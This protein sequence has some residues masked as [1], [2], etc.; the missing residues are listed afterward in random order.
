MPIGYRVSGVWNIKSMPY[1]KV[2]GIWHLCKE[3]VY[4]QS[5]WH[6]IFTDGTTWS[7]VAN[8]GSYM[9]SMTGDPTHGI[10]TGGAL[11]DQQS[12]NSCHTWNGSS[13]N[14]IQDLPSNKTQHGC[15][16][17]SVSC[18]VT[19]GNTSWNTSEIGALDEGQTYKWSG[20]SWSLTNSSNI[21]NT[22]FACIGDADNGMVVG[23]DTIV[24]NMWN[25]STWSVTTSISTQGSTIGCGD[26]LNALVQVQV[27]TSHPTATYVYVWNGSTWSVTTSTSTV[28][29]P[30]LFGGNRWAAL[31]STPRNTSRWTGTTWST[32]NNASLIDTGYLSVLAY[33]SN[34]GN[35]VH[36]LICGECVYNYGSNDAIKWT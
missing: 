29:V 11:T 34:F 6:T 9:G 15:F 19:G 4:K 22:S 33:H 8:L 17:N 12:I 28:Y 30:P 10:A 13:W 18:I 23:G 16:G 35:T 2:S 5:A 31:S 26:V 20:A 3:H 36:S 27:Q 1:A 25:G 14:T 32:T 7:T 21:G 24:S